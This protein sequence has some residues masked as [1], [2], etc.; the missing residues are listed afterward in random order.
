MT[1]TITLLGISLFINMVMTSPLFASPQ[2]HITKPIK[3]T[4]HFVENC[5]PHKRN[6]CSCFVSESVKGCQ[7]GAT[8]FSPLFCSNIQRI[9][10]WI[11]VSG[12]GNLKHGIKSSC[13]HSFRNNA[14]K[15]E[16]I[17]FF[18]HFLKHCRPLR[19]A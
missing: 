15:K 10:F 11:K 18:H 1:K 3:F 6:F 8:I 7:R 19:R 4:N 17:L 13:H 9:L 16:C 5:Y 14:E 2:F 12:G